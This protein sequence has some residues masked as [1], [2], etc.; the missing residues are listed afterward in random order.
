MYVCV[1][2]CAHAI[3]SFLWGFY[4]LHC[5]I[6]PFIIKAKCYLSDN[7]KQEFQQELVL[8]NEKSAASAQ[9]FLFGD[10]ECE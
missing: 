8:K 6:I 4:G 5:I 1:C 10:R 3:E 9:K 7:Y 2:A